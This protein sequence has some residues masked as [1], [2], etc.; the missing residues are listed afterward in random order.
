ME[1]FWHWI[2]QVHL[3]NGRSNGERVSICQLLRDDVVPYVGI[4]AW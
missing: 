2:A 1:T 4:S 3:E